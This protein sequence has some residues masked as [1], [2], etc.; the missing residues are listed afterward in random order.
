MS[1]T[2]SEKVYYPVGIIK[3]E[4]GRI[5]KVVL[6]EASE[7][8]FVALSPKILRS[9]E[10]NG[11]DIR[12]FQKGSTHPDSFFNKIRV[13]N[14]DGTAPQ[15]VLY[16]KDLIARKMVYYL[17]S[18]DGEKRQM[19]RQELEAFMDAGNVVLGAKYHGKKGWQITSQL[20]MN[21]NN[22]ELNTSMGTIKRIP[23]AAEL[24]RMMMAEEASQS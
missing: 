22:S 17:V 1:T 11:Y 12:G 5:D 18:E 8:K 23:R 4:S 2:Y 14:E 9:G 20:V 13:L 15:W 3:R 21:V 24:E 16:R 19:N 10:A 7:E 6:F